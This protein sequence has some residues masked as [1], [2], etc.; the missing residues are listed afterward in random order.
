MSA[1]TIAAGHGARGPFSLRDFLRRNTYAIAALLTIVLLIA[2]LIVQ[3]NFGWV[4]QLATFA[5]LAIAAMAS[6]PSIISGR[7]GFDLTISPLMTFCSA[8]FIIV[9]VPNG[10]GGIEAVPI[11][12]AVGG[13]VGAINGLLIVLLRVPAMVVT[14]AM[15][16]VLIGVNLKFIP[17]PVS[18]TGSWVSSLAGMVGPIP[19]GLIT[20][21]VP[22]IVWGAIGLIPYKRLLYAVGSDDTAAFSSGVNVALVRIVAYVL[23]GVFAGVGSFALVGLVSSADAGQS[24]SYTLVAVAA[25]AL[26]GTALFGGRGGLLGSMLGAAVIYLLQSLLRGLDVNPTWLQLIYGVI[27]V[28]AVVVGAQLT[29][30]KKE[31]A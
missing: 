14:L 27:L 29:R 13:A 10:M 24:S 4:Q 12:L 2:N 11:V 20:I 22:L 30:K 18:M 7:G 17:N 6:T 25:L 3:P 5:P 31:S 15:Y 1:T 21:A 9:L 19:G 26:G 8:V 28:L 16:F 23:G